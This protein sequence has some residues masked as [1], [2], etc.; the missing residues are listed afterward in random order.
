MKRTAMLML[1][2]AVGLFAA[3]S[4][5][6][7]PPDA[8]ITSGSATPYNGYRSS[9]GIEV[10]VTDYDW[11]QNGSMGRYVWHTAAGG[12]SFYWTYRYGGSNTNRRAYYNYYYPPSYWLGPTAMDTRVSR[13]GS[14]DQMSDGRALGAAHADGVGGTEVT[15]YLDAAEGAGTFTAIH[16]PWLGDPANEPS[17]PKIIVDTDDYI[18]VA[19]S[20][21][22]GP[23]SYWNRSTDQGTTWR[24]WDSTAAG[25]E[26]NLINYDYGGHECWAHST[27]TP[28]ISLVNDMGDDYYTIVYWETGDQGNN[29]YFDTAYCLGTTPGDSVRGFIWHSAIYDNDEYVHIVFNCVDTTTGGGG[30]GTYSSG[31]RSQI[32]HW[33]QYTGQ[34]SIVDDGMGWVA[35]NPGPGAN[36]TTVSEPQ[37]T[38]DRATG[39]LYCT[40]CYAD[41]AD[42]APS[43]LVNM[44]IWGAR[45]T[46]NGATWIE[47]HNITNSPSPG[48][49][50]GNCDNDHVNTLAEET[51]GDT[52]IMFYLND[53]DAGNAAYPPDPGATLTDSPLLFYLYKWNP[54]G[55]EENN[56]SAPR[57]LAL[58]VAP[59]PSKRHTAFS[60]ALPTA[61]NVSIKLYSADGRLVQNVYDGR[62]DAG[63]YT[64]SVD[65]SRLANGTY[66]VVLETADEQITSSLVI[67]R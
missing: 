16:P 3:S 56:T 28:W 41:P 2:M 6:T 30:G 66:L 7:M 52:L 33:N 53:K 13:M 38:I 45:S 39:D 29:W 11:M 9:P 60:Y 17:W 55:I 36:H 64:E 12:Y 48:A 21:N 49:T 4:H 40:W 63:H 50:P 19:A 10:G 25:V 46:D 23:Y 24:G 20:Q 65:A 27:T 18:F 37:I 54:P 1:L 5:V 62:R 59:N 51:I 47:R 43:G 8:E 44:D 26:F 14:L 58:N 67:V 61:A 22:G 35:S 31:F 32:R 42:V 57:K 15:L 34:I